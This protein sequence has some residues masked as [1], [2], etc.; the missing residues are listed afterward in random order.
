MD[1]VAPAARAKLFDCEFF[2]LAFFVLAGDVVAPFAS[3]ALKANQ[4]SHV[5]TIPGT[6]PPCS[7]EQGWYCLILSKAHDGNRTHDLFLTK[8]VL[9]RLSYVGIF[10]EPL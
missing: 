5:F 6:L 3:V 7:A 2:R 1:S 8:E 9:Y 4:V 10:D